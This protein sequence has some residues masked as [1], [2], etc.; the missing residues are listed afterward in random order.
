MNTSPPFHPLTEKKAGCR[1]KIARHP[2]DESRGFIFGTVTKTGFY[3][4]KDNAIPAVVVKWDEPV[5]YL[6]GTGKVVAAYCVISL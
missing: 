2:A 6:P 3:Y 4:E 5:S 1:V